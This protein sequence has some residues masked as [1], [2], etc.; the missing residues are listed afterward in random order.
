MANPIVLDLNALE[1]ESFDPIE[2]QEP[3]TVTDPNPWP[4]TQTCKG[5]TSPL[6]CPP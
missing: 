1:V 4:Q 6:L 2:P 5:C 3:G